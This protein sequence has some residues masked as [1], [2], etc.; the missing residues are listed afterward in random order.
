MLAGVKTIQK[1]IVVRNDLLERERACI[2]RR[3]TVGSEDDV[4]AKADGPAHG[5]VN[6]V[7]GHASANDKPGDASSRELRIERGLKERVAST[8]VNYG[9]G[10]LGCNLNSKRPP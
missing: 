5:G 3:V 9:F 10:R 2:S 8:F 6:A 1:R 4:I 7:L